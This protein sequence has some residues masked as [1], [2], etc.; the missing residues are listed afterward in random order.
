MAE[1][2]SGD[3]VQCAA[4]FPPEIVRLSTFDIEFDVLENAYTYPVPIPDPY[5]DA[6]GLVPVTI[7]FIVAL[8]T[9]MRFQIAI[10]PNGRSD[11]RDDWSHMR[12]AHVIAAT[13]VDPSLSRVPFGHSSTGLVGPDSS[14]T[15]HKK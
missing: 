5:A 7:P 9:A 6:E 4:T 2:D 12:Q 3:P 15:V 13:S 10:W 1:P 11:G 8:Q 14:R